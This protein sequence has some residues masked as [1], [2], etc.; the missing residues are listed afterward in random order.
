M[1]V[2]DLVE[3]DA[4][5][6]R[7]GVHVPV[8]DPL[9]RGRQVLGVLARRALVGERQLGHPGCLA[10]HVRELLGLGARHRPLR[11]CV[12]SVR[13]SGSADPLP[14]GRCRVRAQ[15]VGDIA[16]QQVR[17]RRVGDQAEVAGARVPTAPTRR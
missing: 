2:A 15:D 7:H 1:L 12:L 13:S 8:G 16:A 11:S 10:E 3:R 17:I 5:G 6:L 9:G 14:D 4:L